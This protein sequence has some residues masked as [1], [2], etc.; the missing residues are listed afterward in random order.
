[1]NLP[2]QTLPEYQVTLPL[3]GK[4]INYRPYLVRE[5][6]ILLMA[7]ESGDEKAMV[8][9]I[10]KIM[11]NCIDTKI[12]VEDLPLTD[13][14]YLFLKLRIVSV[15]EFTEQKYKCLR[16]ECGNLVTIPLNLNDI[17]IDVA[18]NKKKTIKL[19]DLP[20]FGV[21]MKYPSYKIMEQ[22]GSL[23]FE[24]TIE[25]IKVCIESIFDSENVYSNNQYTDV[26]LNDWIDALTQEQFSKILQFFNDIPILKKDLNFECRVC[27]H[28]EVI[29]LEGITSFFV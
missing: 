22:M 8:V 10:S 18:D 19:S 13:F 7:L 6:K 3:S 27:G 24:K 25:M 26:E 12:K 29:H 20:P 14:E 16:N 1:M 4:K 21:I 9:A 11:Q 28:K 17:S 5:Q 15:G 2:K 23:N